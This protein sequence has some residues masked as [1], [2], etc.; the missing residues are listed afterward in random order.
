MKPVGQLMTE[1]RLIERAIKLMRDEAT[2]IRQLGR[3][4]ISFIYGVVDFIRTYADK[5]HHGK[6]EDILF[7]RAATKKLSQEDSKLLSRLI[8]DHN[9]GRNTTTALLEAANEYAKGKDTLDTIRNRLI[10]LAEFYPK[11][12][13]AEEE[14]FF[15]H[16][17][18]YFTEEE[19]DTMLMD[20]WEYDR[21]MIHTKYQAIV[22]NMEKQEIFTTVS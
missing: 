15:P 4:D 17:E 2:R 5:T 6:E 1:H 12:I 20:F 18:K 14:I 8:D 7:K 9:Y 10:D 19:L 13:R 3:T 16:S 11:H 21:K 22:E